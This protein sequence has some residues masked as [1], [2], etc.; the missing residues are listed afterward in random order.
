MIRLNSKNIILV[1]FYVTFFQSNYSIA[2][3][4]KMIIPKAS[5]VI[6]NV[7]V[8]VTTPSTPVN[9]T[10]PDIN[11][12]PSSVIFKSQ[13]FWKDAKAV[14]SLLALL[15][16]LFNIVWL[17]NNKRVDKINSVKDEFWLRKV[18]LPKIVTP[19]ENLWK[20]ANDEAIA[21]Q[22]DG[23]AHANYVDL[24]NNY[25]IKLMPKVND[26]RDSFDL[27]SSFSLQK[28]EQAND[29]IDEYDELIDG[30][31]GVNPKQLALD[32][33]NKI[34]NFLMNDF[35]LKNKY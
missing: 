4:E 23:V 19:L 11:V 26:V 32:L 21:P 29:L 31:N 9:I 5:V 18:I 25:F 22:F 15:L 33:H 2:C 6:E 3:N 27:L 12:A 24:N 10:S 28:V 34:L 20:E 14:T 30:Y 16:G 13:P 35:H 1:F 8:A 17:I 7:N